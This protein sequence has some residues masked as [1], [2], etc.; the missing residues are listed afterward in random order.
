MFASLHRRVHRELS[1]FHS[2]PEN[3]KT[4]TVSYVLRSIAYPLMSIFTGAF[5]WKSSNDITLLILYYLGNFIALPLMFVVNRRLLSFVPMRYLYL[6]GTFLAGFGP[7]LVIFQRYETPLAYATYGFVYGIGNGLYWAN[8]NF[9]TLTHTTSQSRSYFTGLQFT[10]STLAAM[11]VPPIAGWIIVLTANGYQIL[12]VVASLIFLGSGLIIRKNTFPDTLVSQKNKKLSHTWNTARLLSVAIGCVDSA[13]YVLPTVLVLHVLGNEA[14]LGMVN[15]L[16][17]LL[18]AG[19]SYIVGR[20]Y[21]QSMFTILF[22]AMLLGFVVSGIPFFWGIAIFS[23]AWYLFVSNISDSVIWIANEPVLMDMIDDE[24]K[25]S[26][27]TQYQLII[28]REQFLNIG[29]VSMLLLLLVTSIYN[30]QHAV[31]ITATASGIIA[32]GISAFTWN[33]KNTWESRK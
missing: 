7:V 32:L 24:V 20:K 22:P 14:V 11:I 12:A 31:A 10:L 8:R 29:R 1:H 4:L 13:I 33:A 17:S 19:A 15:S 6:L 9:L 27:V 26:R 18:S 25:H 30:R 16:A 28:E 21:R 5:I 2:M 23:V 3:A